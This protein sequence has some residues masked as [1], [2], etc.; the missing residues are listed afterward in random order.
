M[1]ASD[2]RP[3]RVAVIGVGSLGQHHA[4]IYASLP[5]ARLQAVVDTDL[6]RAAA[7]AARHGV[8]ALASH[9]DLPRDLDAVS[10]AVPTSAHAPIVAA[11][12]ERGLAVLV[13]KPMAAT[14]EEAASMTRAAARAGRP[15]CVGHTERFNPIVRAA[16]RRV[17]DP[18]FIETHRL[19]AF[20]ARGT[21]V[22]VVL[23]LM[24]HDLDVILSLVPSRIASIDSVGVHA[25]TDKVDI[26]NARLRFENDCVANVTA[27]R[28]STERVRKL[29][30]FES[31]SY[32][33]ID[34][35]RQEGVIYTLRRSPGAPPEIVREPIEAENEEPLQA[36]LRAFLRSVRGEDAPVVTGE[37]GLRALETALR[38]V[39][40]IA[41][42]AR[43]TRS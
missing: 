6:D 15:L 34:Y 2:R 13:E 19:G 33:S 5:E 22:D 18:R 43:Q 27:S 31:E 1:A 35:A 26:A 7:I 20:T 42:A 25:L 10:V 14:L 17:R 29:R 37:E 12:L 39:E 9:R 23:D 32:L 38:V 8:L 4:R 36:E 24:I 30:V 41:A 3:V 16:R 28:I 11:C 21:D 40:Q